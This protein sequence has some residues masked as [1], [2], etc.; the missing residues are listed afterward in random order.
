M[1][2][3]FPEKMNPRNSIPKH[4]FFYFIVESDFASVSLMESKSGG[5]LIACKIAYT[6]ENWL[7]GFPRNLQNSNQA[8]NC[9]LAAGY[10]FHIDI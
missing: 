1:L 3:F 2:F 6:E 7:W 9:E 4:E 5:I 10:S 8:C